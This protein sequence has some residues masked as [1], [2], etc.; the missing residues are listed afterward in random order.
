[1]PA[2]YQRDNSLPLRDV[3][4]CFPIFYRR[5]KP[6]NGANRYTMELV[7]TTTP[8]ASAQVKASKRLVLSTAQLFDNANAGHLRSHLWLPG[9]R[10]IPRCKYLSIGQSASAATCIILIWF[11]FFCRRS[12]GW[13]T[14]CCHL[15]LSESWPAGGSTSAKIFIARVPQSL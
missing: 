12:D 14:K 6:S 13:H 2:A 8:I 9:L 10:L 5:C 11:T 7:H 15:F 4:E 1:M 3:D